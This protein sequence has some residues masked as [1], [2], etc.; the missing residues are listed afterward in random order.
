MLERAPKDMTATKQP[1]MMM[2]VG[3][4]YQRRGAERAAMGFPR[5]IDAKYALFAGPQVMAE[6]QFPQMAN[7]S[8]AR[9]SV[10]GELAFQEQRPRGQPAGEMC[11]RH[12]EQN[13]RTPRHHPDCYLF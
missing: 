6:V 2:T 5:S 9:W 8:P 4:W 1:A 10:L 11:D 13:E 3:S 12:A 7:A